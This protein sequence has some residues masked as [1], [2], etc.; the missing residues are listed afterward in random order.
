MFR[1]AMLALDTTANV[2]YTAAEE[3]GTCSGAKQGG[4]GG[5]RRQGA[6]DDTTPPT[7]PEAPQSRPRAIA[8]HWNGVQDAR[9]VTV[10]S[11]NTQSSGHQ[12][13]KPRQACRLGLQ[14]LRTLW[15]HVL[16]LLR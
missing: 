6:L 4:G 11:R 16:R 3:R 9:H 5:H 7:L 14:L 8:A 1:L 10:S 15:W 13:V 2:K 12:T